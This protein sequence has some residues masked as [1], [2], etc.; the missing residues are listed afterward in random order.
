V[1]R[2]FKSNFGKA[3]YVLRSAQSIAAVLTRRGLRSRR[4]TLSALSKQRLRRTLLARP[5]ASLRN[6][7]RRLVRR[8]KL[9]SLGSY[10]TTSR[11]HGAMRKT[12]L[13]RTVVGSLVSII[14]PKLENLSTKPKY[15]R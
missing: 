12:F 9:L 13:A 1:L 15:R 2:R 4:T 11:V 7:L 5:V 10:D 14:S 3:A 6:N 8:K